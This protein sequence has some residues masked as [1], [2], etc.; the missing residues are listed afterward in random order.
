MVKFQPLK[1]LWLFSLPPIFIL[2]SLMIYQTIRL[3][4]ASCYLLFSLFMKRLNTNGLVTGYLSNELRIIDYKMRNRSSQSFTVEIEKQFLKPVKE[5][6]QALYDQGMK[7]DKIAKV[8]S[9]HKRT[10]YTHARNF[11]IIKEREINPKPKLDPFWEGFY[12][13]ELNQ[14]NVFSRRR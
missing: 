8:L 3:F 7:T 1:V 14:F 6:L 4:L 2:I 11:G 13:K 10:I 9:F 5:V 12:Q